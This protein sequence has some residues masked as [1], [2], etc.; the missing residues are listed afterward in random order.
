MIVFLSTFFKNKLKRNPKSKL[1][2]VM[3]SLIENNTSQ[4]M[5]GK[6]IKGEGDNLQNNEQI[7]LILIKFNQNK[8]HNKRELKNK[9]LT[10]L[11]YNKK[12]NV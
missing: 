8:T 4:K 11:K 12:R 10:K 1:K 7:R 3:N 2:R 9:S 5:M 6:K